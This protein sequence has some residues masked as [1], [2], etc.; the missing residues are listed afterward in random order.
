[1]IVV[2]ICLLLIFSPSYLITYLF[3]PS[4]FPGTL[5]RAPGI[6]SG[7]PAFPVDLIM[8]FISRSS[9]ARLVVVGT[10]CTSRLI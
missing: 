10:S 3:F 7:V 1:M 4:L 9:L 8:L 2:N 6:F 5:A